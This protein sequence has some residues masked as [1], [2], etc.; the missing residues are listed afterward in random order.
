VHHRTAA[1]PAPAYA[2]ERATRD[3]VLAA[4]A[5]NRHAAEAVRRQRAGDFVGEVG[6]R[7]VAAFYRHELRRHLG[8][9]QRARYARTLAWIAGEAQ[10]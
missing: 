5:A 8:V 7:A 3:A 9:A 6:A 10:A 4:R 1:P 2:I